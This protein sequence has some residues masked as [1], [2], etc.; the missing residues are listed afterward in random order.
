VVGG[1]AVARSARCS[2]CGAAG[3]GTRG[4]CGPS[5]VID[6]VWRWLLP[7]LLGGTLG[8][9]GVFCTL[10]AGWLFCTLGAV[11]VL[12]L[13]RDLDGVVMVGLC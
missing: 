5:L 4:P 10:G 1:G 3:A 7:S 11:G 2:I 8:A 9:G 13:D 12:D 6:L